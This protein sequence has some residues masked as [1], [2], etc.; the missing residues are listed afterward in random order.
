MRAGLL[1]KRARFQY[2]LET[3]DGAG[4]ASKEW[5][6][7][8]TLWA[9]FSPERARERIQQGRIGEN[10][11]GVI[12]IRY[13]EIADQITSAFRVLLDG[14]T[15]NIRDRVVLRRDGMIELSVE[16]DGAEG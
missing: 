11:A 16:T 4:G 15:Y 2:A 13:S 10:Y 8:A 7:H 5:T 6:D 1:D 3:A 9:Q 12:R 14:V